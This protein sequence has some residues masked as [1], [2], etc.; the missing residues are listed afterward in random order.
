MGFNSAFKGLNTNYRVRHW[1]Q[2]N[3]QA[4]LEQTRPLEPLQGTMSLRNIVNYWAID[5]A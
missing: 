4:V 2:I 1:K 5:M 3:T